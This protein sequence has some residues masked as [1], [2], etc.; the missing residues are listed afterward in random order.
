MDWCNTQGMDP[1]ETY[2]LMSKALNGT[3][4]P[5]HFNVRE[6]GPNRLQ[7]CLT[8]ACLRC[9]SGVKRTPGS[10]VTK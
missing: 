3:A 6:G 10:G 2:P 1:K 4:R 8:H 9:A 5:I 7:S